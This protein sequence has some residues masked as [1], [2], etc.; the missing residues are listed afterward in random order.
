[1]AI[2][3]NFR[4]LAKVLGAKHP[5]KTY[6]KVLRLNK[7]ERAMLFGRWYHNFEK[8]GFET[9]VYN[10]NHKLNQ[11]AKQEPMRK[12]ILKALQLCDDNSYTTIK[13]VELFCADGLYANM[14]IG[15]GASKMVGV[16][17]NENEIS[18]AKLITKI[19]GNQS[20]I[21]YEVKDVFN[22]ERTYDFGICAGGLYHLHDPSKLLTFLLSKIRKV[23]VIQTVYS[24]ARKE[25]DYFET[26]APGWDWG[27]RFSYEYLLRM[28]GSSGWCILESYCNELEG[29][30]R[31]DDRGSAYLLCIPKEN[32]PARFPQKGNRVRRLR[33]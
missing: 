16:D 29:N 14:A 30:D 1:M 6:I 26:P 13:G 17:I 11:S 27:C 12:Y 24:L 33:R 32:H 3:D 20:K 7:V 18:K 5:V 10:Q 22:L 31:L 19:L 25:I 28:V 8:L 23:L 15:L 21:T 4:M 9:V 2:K